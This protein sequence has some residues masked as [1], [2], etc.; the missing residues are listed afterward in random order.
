[1]GIYAALREWTLWGGRARMAGSARGRVLELGVGG[2]ANLPHYRL[3]RA[4]VGLDPRNEALEFARAGNGSGA[5]GAA[6]AVGFVAA[7]GEALPF[8]SRS[9]DTIVATLVLCSVSDP[10]AS[11]V[12]VRRVLRSRGELRLVE[13]VRPRR[14]I[15]HLLLGLAG[16]AWFRFSRECHIDRD[17]V[18][19]LESAGFRIRQLRQHVGGVFVE[20]VAVP[21]DP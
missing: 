20:L 16:P 14:G 4:I 5:N 21:R 18:T 3:A 1:M 12:E 7:R 19:T 8:P 10:R 17:T 9:F 11:L 2:G 13:H 6:P 15:L